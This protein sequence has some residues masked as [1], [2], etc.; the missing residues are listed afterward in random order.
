MT[1]VVKSKL[2][3]YVRWPRL[4]LCWASCGSGDCQPGKPRQ[5]GQPRQP[6]Q[7]EECLVGTEIFHLLDAQPLVYWFSTGRDKVLYTKLI[8][9]LLFSYLSQRFV[10]YQQIYC[11]KKK[12][13]VSGP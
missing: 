3:P 12:I 13:L 6:R 2:V 1:E 5:P 10:E 9:D 7:L 8:F 11:P 4:V